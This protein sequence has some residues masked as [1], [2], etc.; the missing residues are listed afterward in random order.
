M[1]DKESPLNFKDSNSKDSP[2]KE[3]HMGKSNQSHLTFMDFDRQEKKKE[4][5][6][7]HT[8]AQLQAA[9]QA[10]YEQ[11]IE[12]GRKLEKNAVDTQLLHSLMDFQGKWGEFIEEERNKRVD[13]QKRAV[14]L[15]KTIAYKI[16]VSEIEKNAAE[17]VGALMN[18]VSQTLLDDPK[19]N[20]YVNPAHVSLLSHYLEKKDK[21][22]VKS[23]ETL[24]LSDCRFDWDQGG[25]EFLLKDILEKIDV[26]IQESCGQED[27]GQD[28]EN[29]NEKNQLKKGDK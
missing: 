10:F 22:Q 21:I 26:I 8:S 5:E 7:K 13:V 14:M 15:A 11:G 27:C 4:D 17:R 1:D 24:G 16:G 28:A 3:S 6:P 9:Q 12:H 2:L 19:I 23:D 18:M 25:A 29:E 20:L